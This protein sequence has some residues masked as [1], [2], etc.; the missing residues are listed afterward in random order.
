MKHLISC[1]LVITLL[2]CGN[3][4]DEMSNDLLRPSKVDHYASLMLNECTLN[5]PYFNGVHHMTDDVTEDALAKTETKSN[6]QMIYTWRREIELNENG[7]RRSV[8][9]AWASFYRIIAILN[10]ILLEINDDAGTPEEIACIKGEAHFLRAHAY[11]HLVNLYALP[12]D[13]ATAQKA[14]GVPL[15]LDH[16]VEVT[17]DRADLAACYDQI[18][19]DLAAG[20]EEFKKTSI[21][22]TKWHPNLAACELLWSRV[23]L[24]RRQWQEAISHAGEVI[25]RV[26]LTKLSPSTP[27]VTAS[28]PEIIYS[29]MYWKGNLAISKTETSGYALSPELLTCYDG[30]NDLRYEACF[31]VKGGA[32]KTVIYSTKMEDSYSQLGAFNLRGAEAYLNRAEAY[33]MLDNI[34]AAQADLKALIAKRYRRPDEVI[35][36]DTPEELLKFIQ[37]ERRREFAWEDHHR[38]Y[39]LRRMSERPE[40]R[41]VFTYVNNDGMR[42]GRVA[43]RLLKNDA[44]YVLPIPMAERDNN[45]LIINNDRL[46]KIAEP[47]N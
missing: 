26:A 12:Y 22:K 39:D 3:F 40:I 35:L 23:K 27:F 4:L 19:K 41:H 32:Q 20:C 18:E 36:P 11:F 33:V 21:V 24:Y 38:W 2:G 14:L 29:F 7:E 15:R 13:P 8:N 42:S 28:N 34:S 17:Y 1:F 45:P 30:L 43:Y 37:D 25:Q 31:S 16:A 5:A 10:D 6:L 46:E 47:V 9:E 44:N